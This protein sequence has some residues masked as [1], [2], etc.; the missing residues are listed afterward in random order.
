[1]ARCRYSSTKLR[2]SVKLRDIILNGR[3]CVL[4]LFFPL[5]RN[6]FGKKQYIYS[7][8]EHGTDPPVMGFKQVYNKVVIRWTTHN[9]LGLSQKDIEMAKFCDERGAE[10]GDVD[11]GKVER[12]PADETD[13]NVLDNLLGQGVQECG[14]CAE[15]SKK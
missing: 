7:P 12:A 9:P 6:I 2:T 14:P 11:T 15:K 13:G 4:R 5:L 8:G 3:M 1:M 10:L